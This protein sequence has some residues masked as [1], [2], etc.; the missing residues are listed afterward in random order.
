[1]STQK[2]FL[3][4][5]ILIIVFFIFSQIMIAYALHTTYK[6]K[7]TD[8]KTKYI[9]DVEVKASSIDGYATG[10][11]KNDEANTL[12]NKYIKVETY[13]K[14]DVLMGTKYIKIDDINAN[15]EKEFEVHFNFKKVEKT[16]I[17]IVEE[18]DVEEVEGLSFEDMTSDPERNFIAIVAAVVI[19]HFI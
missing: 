19:L 2:K 6:N 13:S 18:K 1:M 9:T 3:I 12:Q 15:E 11:V 10:K 4:Y 7:D 14:H 16:I 5:L 17:D 8:V